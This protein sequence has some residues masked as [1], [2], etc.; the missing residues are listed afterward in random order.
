MRQTSPISAGWTPYRA[1]VRQ[2]RRE[3]LLL[4]CA[5]PAPPAAGDEDASPL[6][7]RPACPPALPASPSDPGRARAHLRGP[8]GHAGTRA[9]GFIT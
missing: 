2:V 4:G 5:H 1:L 8:P 9:S 3:A 6:A 7:A